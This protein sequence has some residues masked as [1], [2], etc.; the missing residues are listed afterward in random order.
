MAQTYMEESLNH[1]Q[2][3]RTEHLNDVLKDY[4]TGSEVNHVIGEATTRIERLKYLY[5]FLNC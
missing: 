4:K 2:I 5:Y 1:L 3:M